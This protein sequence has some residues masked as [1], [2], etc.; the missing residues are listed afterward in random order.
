MLW[1]KI[2]IRDNIFIV[3]NLSADSQ[4]VVTMTYKSHCDSI[5]ELVIEPVLVD[6]EETFRMPQKDGVYIININRVVDNTI[7]ETIPYEYPYYRNLINSI[8][9]DTEKFLCNGCKCQDCDDE[10][11]PEETEILNLIVKMYS[12]YTLMYK[13]QERF[14]NTVFSC[15]KCDIQEITTCMIINET[16]LG[17][18]NIKQLLKKFIS[19]FYLSFYYGEYY[20]NTDKNY[21]NK[22][23]KYRDILNCVKATNLEIECITNKIENNMGTFQVT[24]EQH[25]NQPPSSVGDYTTTSSNRS[26]LV[27]TPA[28]L[29]SLTTP[30]YADPENDAA[31]AVRIDSL[32]TN[33][34]TLM[35]GSTPVTLGQVITMSVVAGGTLVLVGPNQDAISNSI[36]TFSLRDVGSMQFSS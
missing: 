23:F 18:P 17:D 9:K 7:L 20:N 16:V 36:F 6:F 26:T 11:N 13:Y 4:V 30:A 27:I 31:Q 32:A 25:I 21:V 24:F 5:E 19:S 28:M 1:Y 33:G 14:F 12:Y 15:L 29:T 10:C 22:K 34:A 2:D 3:T 35:L 8:I